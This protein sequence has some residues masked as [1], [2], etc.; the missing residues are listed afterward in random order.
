MTDPTDAPGKTDSAGVS[1]EEL[2]ELA[3]TIHT[4]E[5]FGRAI[6]ASALAEA[7]KRGPDAGSLSA[8]VSVRPVRRRDRPDDTAGG[9]AK[10][11]YE[12]P[13][14]YK[15]LYSLGKSGPIHTIEICRPW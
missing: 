10:G 14:C 13:H 6:V 7:A 15:I 5:S 3:A 1:A 4:Y 2:E 12:D 11:H 8:S 9:V